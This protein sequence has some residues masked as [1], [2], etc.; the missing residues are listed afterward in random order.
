MPQ[1]AIPETIIVDETISLQLI[2]S[3]HAQM[4]FDLVDQNTDS[5]REWLPWVPHMQTLS[6]FE[7]YIERCKQQHSAGTDV[8]YVIT[9]KGKAAGRIGIHYIDRQNS[10]GA[11]GYWLSKE[12]VGQGVV[13]RACEAIVRVAFENL[14]LHRLEIRCATGNQ[15][16]A[17]IAE[18]LGFAKEGILRQAEFVNGRFHDLFLFALLKEDWLQPKQ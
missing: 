12:Y 2:D 5:L 11:I 18:R 4:L 14:G 3:F 9:V 16:S 6:N 15:K 17:A 8:G 13:T 7:A 10:H 1:S